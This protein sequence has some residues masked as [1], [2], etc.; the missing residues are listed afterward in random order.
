M[1]KKS[2]GLFT[3]ECPCC[4]ATLKVDPELHA[5]IDHVEHVKPREV[6]DIEAAMN[7]FQ[8]EASRREDA[9]QK[10]VEQQKHSKEI[11]DK[12]FEEM[13]KKVKENPD[14]PRPQRDIDWD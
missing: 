12:K 2:S 4:K 1:A 8:G 13:F 9:F 10:S 14:M 7:R 6:A 11:L 5:V 3:V